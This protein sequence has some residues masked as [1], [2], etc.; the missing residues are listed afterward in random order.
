MPRMD[1]IDFNQGKFKRTSVRSWDSD[2]LSSL[3]MDNDENNEIDGLTSIVPK[4]EM[5]E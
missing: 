2:L 3:K 4:K 5:K 1:D